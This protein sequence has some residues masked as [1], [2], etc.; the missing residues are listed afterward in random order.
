MISDYLKKYSTY[1]L[2]R[3]SVTK[4][5]FQDIL[6]KKITKDFLEKKLNLDDRIN[7]ENQIPQVAKYFEKLGAFNE[8]RLI[9]ITF[10]SY[11]KK[12]YSKQKIKYKM[13]SCKFREPLASKFLAKMF[14]NHRFAESL[15]KNYLKRSRIIEKQKKLNISEE[16]LFDKILKKLANQ[17]FNYEE[18]KKVLNELLS[19]GK[20]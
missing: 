10:Q 3:Y 17:G 8:E 2:T 9:E 12:G 20:L 15:V 5:K 11:V 14:E 6:K 4:K 19:D 7:F 1:Y 18:S 13:S 16:Q